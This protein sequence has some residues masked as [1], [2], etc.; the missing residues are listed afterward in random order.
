[1]KAIACEN[2]HGGQTK[3]QA[4]DKKATYLPQVMHASMDGG[5]R[6]SLG[7]Q[8]A[9]LSAIRMETLKRRYIK[10]YP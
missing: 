5:D 9:R 10:I 4:K 8:T 2:L 7:E 3:I 1:M 6:L